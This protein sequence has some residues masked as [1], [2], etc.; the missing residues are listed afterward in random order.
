M[1]KRVLVANRGAIAVRI[2]RT[3]HAMNIESV[4][5]YAENR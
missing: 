3:L 4:G 1:I 2:V 5:V